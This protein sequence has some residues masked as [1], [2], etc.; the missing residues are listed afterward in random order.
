LSLLGFTGLHLP[1]AIAMQHGK[2][3]YTFHGTAGADTW[4]AL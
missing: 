3:C 2:E 4:H 1:I